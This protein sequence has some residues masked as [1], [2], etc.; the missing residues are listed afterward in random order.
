[1]FGEGGA[2]RFVF[3]G[4]AG[5]DR[6]LDFADRDSKDDD[7]LDFSRH[8]FAS[9]NQIAK[10][11]SGKNLA[12]QFGNG[13]EVMLVAISRTTASMPSTTTS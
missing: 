12:L 2:D 11:A 8:S 10:I 5:A 6:I 1:M 3:N 7:T 13:N 4:N 9:L